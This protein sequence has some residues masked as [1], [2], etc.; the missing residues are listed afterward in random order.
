MSSEQCDPLRG[1]ARRSGSPK[2]RRPLCGRRTMS[3]F[4]FRASPNL[5]VSRRPGWAAPSRQSALARPGPV[6]ADRPKS[7]DL[8]EDSGQLRERCLPHLL[9][10][11]TLQ[12]GCAPISWPTA[13]DD[14]RRISRPIGYELKSDW[15]KI[16]RSLVRALFQLA[17]DKFAAGIS[18]WGT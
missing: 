9:L 2:A 18:L 13:A 4:S 10:I 15:V 5:Q 3:Q 11:P 6:A 16:S 17:D 7:A 1:C 14:A 12:T 8:L